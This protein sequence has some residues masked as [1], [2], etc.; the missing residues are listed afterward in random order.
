MSTSTVAAPPPAGF[1]SDREDQRRSQYLELKAE[2]HR[3]LL[4]RLNL[5]TLATT[6]RAHAENEIRNLTTS[7]IGEARAP[8]TMAEREAILGDVLDEVFGF[9]PLEPLLRDKTVTEEGLH[10]GTLTRGQNGL[11]VPARRYLVAKSPPW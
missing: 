5:E 1:S 8:L 6:D 3:K 10:N 7:L 11:G 9:G 4:G 2:I